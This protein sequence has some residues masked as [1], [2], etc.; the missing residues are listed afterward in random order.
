MGKEHKQ[1]R[2]KT[3][4]SVEGRS[5]ASRLNKLERPTTTRGRKDAFQ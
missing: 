5:T 2:V 3:S 4:V 1:R